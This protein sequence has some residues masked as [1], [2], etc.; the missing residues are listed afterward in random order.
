MF[1]CTAF[2]VVI[3]EQLPRLFSCRISLSV[4]YLGYW[5][6]AAKVNDAVYIVSSILSSHVMYLFHLLNIVSPQSITLVAY[7]LLNIWDARFF[8][9]TEFILAMGMS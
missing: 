3:G 1:E 2:S 6:S 7:F 4:I 5:A 9:D 8:A